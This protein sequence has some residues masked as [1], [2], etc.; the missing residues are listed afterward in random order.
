MRGELTASGWQTARKSKHRHAVA[1]KLMRMLWGVLLGGVVAVPV[2]GQDEPAMLDAAAVLESRLVEAIATAEKSVVAIARVRKEQRRLLLDQGL[3][4][5]PPAPTDPQFIPQEYGTG[6]IIDPEGYILTAYH[7]LGNPEEN[8]YYVWL[9][10][11]GYKA[12]PVQSTM[13]GDPWL[14]LAVL[15][16]DAKDLPPIRFGDADTLKKGQIVIALGN[17]LA[18]ARDGQASASWG[19]V[20]NLN[21][22]AAPY[23]AQG[24]DPGQGRE[25]LHHF[26]T[27]IQTDA[28]LNFGTSGGALINLKGEMVGLLVSLSAGPLY[29]SAAGFAIPVDAHFKRTVETLKAGRRPEYGFLGVMPSSLSPQERV[30]GLRGARIQDVVPGTPADR[31]NLRPGD[32][33]LAVNQAPVYDEFDLIRYISSYPPEATVHITVRRGN[34][35]WNAP[36]KLA[37][38]ALP[39]RRVAYA[40]QPDPTWRGLAVD[41]VT[42]LP[43]YYQQLRW[44]GRQEAVGVRD[45]VQGSPAWQ[46]GL[47]PGDLITAVEGKPIGSPRAFWEAVEPRDGTVQLRV[48]SGGREATRSV[49]AP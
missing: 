45:V 44:R 2:A 35:E 16:I 18:I 32:L 38:K 31:A 25:T 3:P 17:P 1:T 34:Q 42:A 12:I 5:A 21:R 27:L 36:V 40:S 13:A 10:R 39:G 11:A 30:Q 24:S 48:I 22:K 26:G 46:A 14:D 19:I 20:S 33:V 23:P 8:D 28:R 41:Y 43:N 37:K 9:N 6:V 7:V 49:P 47:R 29:D 15:K 4:G